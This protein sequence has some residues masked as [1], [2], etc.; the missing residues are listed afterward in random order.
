[1]DRIYTPIVLVVKSGCSVR[2]SIKALTETHKFNRQS[3]GLFKVRDVGA[4]EI[5]GV[6][7]KND[8]YLYHDY[9]KFIATEAQSLHSTEPIK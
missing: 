2:I 1:M 5:S 9:M 6:T 3:I 8:L 4:A 7:F